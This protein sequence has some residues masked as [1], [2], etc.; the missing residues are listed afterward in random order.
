MTAALAAV[1]GVLLVA[2]VRGLP[3]PLASYSF[4]DS[5]ADNFVWPAVYAGIRSRAPSCLRRAHTRAAVR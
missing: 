1:L 5:L 3:N 2:L 4:E